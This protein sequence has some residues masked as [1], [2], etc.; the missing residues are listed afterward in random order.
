MPAAGAG[1][2]AREEVGVLREAE[3]WGAAQGVRTDVPA[4]EGE[5]WGGLEGETK[6]WYLEVMGGMR[7]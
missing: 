7:L 4:G 6:A 1:E 3:W 5:G 2:G